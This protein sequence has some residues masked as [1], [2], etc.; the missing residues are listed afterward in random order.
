MMIFTNMANNTSVA[1]HDS[2]CYSSRWIID[3][4]CFHHMSGNKTLFTD[5]INNSPC[6]VSLPNGTKALATQAGTI[7]L[8]DSCP[9]IMFCMLQI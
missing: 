3:S 7:V 4:G 2:K 6:P 8:S 1:K 5:L 9:S